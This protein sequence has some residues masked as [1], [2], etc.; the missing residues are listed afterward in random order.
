MITCKN[1]PFPIVVGGIPR[2]DGQELPKEVTVAPAQP[3]KRAAII[4]Y[5]NME[6]HVGEALL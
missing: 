3:K 5:E 2:A 6:K 1:W 4:D